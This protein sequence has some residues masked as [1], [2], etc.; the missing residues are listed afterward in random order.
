MR[1]SLYPKSKGPE[2]AG[3]GVDIVVNKM[4]KHLPSF[5]VE[6][7]EDGQ[8]YDVRAVHISGDG[9]IDVLHCHGL[10]PT[11]K[12]GVSNVTWM[13]EL[14]KQVIDATRRARFVTV[15]SRWVGELFA[16]DM[17]FWPVVIPHG[18]DADDFPEPSYKPVNRVLWNKNR[19][20]DVCDPAPVNE[21]AR[22]MPDYRFIT[23]FGTQSTNVVVT[24]SMQ[25]PKMV[26]LLYSTG[27]VYLATTKETFGIGTLE[28]MAAGMPVLAWDWGATPSLVEHGKTGCIVKPGDIEGSRLG[29]EYILDNYE[30]LAREARLSALRYNWPAVIKQYVDVYKLAYEQAQADVHPLVSV[31]I[32]CYNYAKYVTDAI[33]SVKAQTYDN[34]ECIVVD[35][36]SSDNS[37][38][39]ASNA[40]GGDTRFKLV[41]QPNS[42]VA[43]ARNRGAVESHGRYLMFLDADDMLLST[44]IEKLLAVITKSRAIGQVYGKLAIMDAD[45]KVSPRIPD[46]PGKFAVDLQVSGKNQ[47]PSCNMMRREAF[48]R[49]GG[50]RQHTAPQEDAEL[51]TRIP[52]VGY[53]TEMA[54]Q[55]PVYKY[56]IHE[57]A[58]T[59]AIREGKATEKNW[60][61]YIAVHNGAPQPFASV[62]TP[63]NGRSHLV[64]CFDEPHISV[65]IPCGDRHG[66]LLRDAIESVAAQ[67]DYHWEIIV[68]DDTDAGDLGTKGHYP[69][70]KQYP[71]VRWI[72]NQKLHNVSAARNI[73]AEA[74]RGKYLVFLDADDYLLPDFLTRTFAIQKECQGDGSLVYTDWITAPQ[75]ESHVA[76][77]WSLERLMD[78]AIFAVTFMHTKAIWK[79]VGGFSEDVLLWEDWDYVL[80]L[81]MAGA[82][83]IRVPKALFVYRYNTGTRRRE[84]LNNKDELLQAIRGKYALIVPK[85][86]K[87]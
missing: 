24:G 16:H 53:Y 45:G 84:S 77:N 10:Y 21:I 71:Y 67:S 13:L 28:A 56:R 76:E 60:L 50:F 48:F 18:I 19:N 23:T 41:R 8:P 80:K 42:G 11:G 85:K 58:A 12:F 38:E 29:I 70:S 86:R 52:L 54:T 51:W 37:A 78:H 82:K 69:Y 30:S 36:G 83:G 59:S 32:P 9:D 34:W 79:E 20:T 17:G 35:D 73:G 61:E 43:Q 39:V 81:A 3:S 62:V 40:F 72:R 55:D 4:F 65:I 14:N 46:W 87:G 5:G 31:I 6:L 64:G 63:V 1:V 15:P 7:V 57:G 27:G 26:E 2:R 68:V 75:M 25:H 33:N 74:A 44:C 49:T 66:S 47:V 22:I